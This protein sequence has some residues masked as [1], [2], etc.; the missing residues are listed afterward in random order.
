[1]SNYSE[2]TENKTFFIESHRQDPA[3]CAR[4]CWDYVSTRYL[5]FCT[6]SL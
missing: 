5:Q 4:P 6:A 3:A 2:D 1:M